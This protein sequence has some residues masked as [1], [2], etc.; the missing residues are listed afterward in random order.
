MQEGLERSIQRQR[1][2]KF[3][4]YM[5]QNVL[6]RINTNLMIYYYI[7]W[8]VEFNRVFNDSLRETV[9][10]LW[11]KRDK[12]NCLLKMKTWISWRP[13]ATSADEA[14]EKTSNC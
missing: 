1:L 7:Q 14:L 5:S 13:H 6:K 10:F 4:L 12:R 11:L 3:F 8:F 2:S 9:L